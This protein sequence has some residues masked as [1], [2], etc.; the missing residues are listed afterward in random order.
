MDQ[1]F[2]TPSSWN[3]DDGNGLDSVFAYVSV[4]SGDTYEMVADWSGHE[5]RWSGSF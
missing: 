2:L 4:D 1:K 3:I 5:D